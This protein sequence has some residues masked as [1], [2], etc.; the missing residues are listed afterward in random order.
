MGCTREELVARAK[1]WLG[2]REKDGS[3]K[4]IIDVY[5]SHTPRARGYKLQYTDPWCAG[6]VSACAI[7]CDATDV[8]PL[9]VSCTKMIALAKEMGIWVEDDNYIPAPAD[10]LL[11]DWQDSGKGDNRGSPN[12]VGIVTE[13]KDGKLTVTEGNYQNAVRDRT[14]KIGGKYIRGYIVP[15]YAQEEQPV[16][17]V[18]AKD[19]ARAFLASLS[20]TYQVTASRGLNVR[21]G[22]GTHKQKMVSIPKGTKVRCWGYYTPYLGRNWLYIRFTCKGVKY[23]GFASARYLQEVTV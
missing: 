23:T 20:G 13:V 21:H 12:H 18:Q 10:I 8:I 22:A 19:P 4:Q 6:F 16:S 2:C 17:Q 7:A 11:Y 14:L 9:E 3:H 1:S 15:K 5:N